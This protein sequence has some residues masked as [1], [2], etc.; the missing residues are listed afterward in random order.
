MGV[1][2]VVVGVTQVQQP[3][4][5]VGFLSPWNYPLTLAASDAIPALLAGN[6]V[7][8]KPDVQTSLTALWIVD[9]H[10]ARRR[11]GHGHPGRH[12]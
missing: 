6:A 11:P 9:L 4:G 3:K 2:P 10:G 7:I 1:F 5:V 12:R 8:I